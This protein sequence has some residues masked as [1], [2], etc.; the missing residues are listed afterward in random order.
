MLSVTSNTLRLIAPPAVAVSFQEMME[1]KALE[2]LFLLLAASNR[3]LRLDGS[4][5]SRRSILDLVDFQCERGVSS[6]DKT[7]C[8]AEGFA[9]R[10]L[11]AGTFELG[12]PSSFAAAIDGF[13]HGDTNEVGRT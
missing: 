7:E 12:A 11:G 9:P 1:P 8:G 2:R 10:R 5:P 4:P 13:S 3:P 6:P